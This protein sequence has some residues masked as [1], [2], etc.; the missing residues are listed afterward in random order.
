MTISSSV[1]PPEVPA[2]SHGARARIVSAKAWDVALETAVQLLP[3]DVG[4][5]LSLLAALPLSSFVPGW[6]VRPFASQ[7]V[8]AGR[9]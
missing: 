1:L 2:V 8:P 3:A 7:S 6:C 5:Q 9:A 4:E